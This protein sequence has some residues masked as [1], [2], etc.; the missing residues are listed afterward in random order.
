MFSSMLASRRICFNSATSPK[1]KEVRLQNL[2]LE[3]ALSLLTWIFSDS[4]RKLRNADP[5]HYKAKLPS[6]QQP[7]SRRLDSEFRNMSA[8]NHDTSSEAGKASPARDTKHTLSWCHDPSAW[9]M[10]LLCPIERKSRLHSDLVSRSLDLHPST[11]KRRHLT[12]LARA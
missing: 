7:S 9:P 3:H 2:Q 4:Q 8:C 1:W 12:L 6:I 11:L 5:A 10:A